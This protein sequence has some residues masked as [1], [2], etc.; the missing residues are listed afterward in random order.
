[1]FEAHIVPIKKIKIE[2]KNVLYKN[3]SSTNKNNFSLFGFKL[4]NFFKTICFICSDLRLLNLGELTAAGVAVDL[5]EFQTWSR[6]AIDSVRNQ[7][8]NIWYPAI[9]SIYCLVGY[10]LCSTGL[11]ALLPF[12]LFFF[13]LFFNVACF[14]H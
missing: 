2:T 12:A 3:L 1:M 8:M 14:I 6:K 4:K 10:C 13:Y 9:Q 7:L 5:I 11:Q